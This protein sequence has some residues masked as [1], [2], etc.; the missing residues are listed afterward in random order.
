MAR[1]PLLRTAEAAR[2]LGLSHRTLEKL[3]ATGGGPAFLKIG[4]AVRY[5]AEDLARFM[6][7]HR[8]HSTPQRSSHTSAR[9]TDEHGPGTAD[10]QRG[11]VER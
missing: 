9:V 11:L 3:R 4:R 1:E 7:A 5:S 8:R 6:A 10:V 2:W